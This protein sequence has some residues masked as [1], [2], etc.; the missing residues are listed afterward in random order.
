M[1]RKASLWIT[2]AFSTSPT[3]GIESLA[4]PIPVHLHLQ[5]M[6]GCANFRAATLSDIH[7]CDQVILDNCGSLLE[8]DALEARE[9]NLFTILWNV[10]LSDDTVYCSVDASLPDNTQHQAVLAA[11]LYREVEEFVRICP[12]SPHTFQ[13]LL[14]NPGPL[15]TC[16]DHS[17]SVHTILGYFP[18]RQLPLVSFLSHVSSVAYISL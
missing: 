17:R 2:G 18:F 3:G 9:H 6:A 13:T 4:G 10:R 1:E 11:I 12:P 5:K 8:Q 15:W 7:P 14:D 16:L